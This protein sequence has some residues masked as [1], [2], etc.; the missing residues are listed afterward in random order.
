MGKGKG[1]KIFR[2][3]YLEIQEDKNQVSIVRP[4]IGE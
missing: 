4:E 3:C 2:R 1:N